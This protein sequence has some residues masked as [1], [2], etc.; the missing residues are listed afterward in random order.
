M[1]A[2]LSNLQNAVTTSMLIKYSVYALVLTVIILLVIYIRNKTTL[3]NR[4]CTAID[5]YYKEFPTIS[6]FNSSDAQYNY[7]LKDYYI[8]TAHNACSTGNFTNSFV[9]LCALKQA[10]RQGYRALDFEI[11]SMGND[12]V[13]ATSAKDSFDYKQTYN[14]IGFGDVCKTIADHA[15]SSGSCP[16]SNDP[17]LIHLRIKSN[18]T[19]I[20]PKMASHIAQYLNRYVLGK[21]YS[22][23][24]N[25]NNIGNLPLKQLNQKVIIIADKSN[26]DF[27]G[28]E[29]NEYVNIASNSIFMHTYRYDEIKFNPSP[30]ELIEFNKKNMSIVLPN[31]KS[32]DNNPSSALPMKYGCQLIAM[33]MQAFDPNIQYYDKLFADHGSAFVL[34]PENL[35]FKPVTITVPQQNPKSYSYAKRDISSDFYKFNI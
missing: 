22:Y 30:D 16:N 15:F 4:N 3:K 26:P 1:R 6:S 5:K 27:E 20:Y 17:L 2:L 34:K 35:R 19:V 24:F 18:N 12:P 8:K 23:E 21:D 7:T 33:N 9:D 10:I 13:I 28:T 25:G 14:A 31:L 11:Y 29:L 32:S